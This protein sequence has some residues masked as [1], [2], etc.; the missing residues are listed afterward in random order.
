VKDQALVSVFLP[1]Y[2]QQ[3]FIADSICSV[4]SQ[5][6]ENI[7][8][9]I[10][11]DCSQDNTWQIVEEYKLKYPEKINAF[12]NK[13]NLGITGNCNEILRRCKGKYVVYTA[14]DDLFLPGKISAQVDLMS[15]NN[16][17]VLCYHDIE[18][19]KSKDNSTIRY[20]NRGIV[21][22]KPVVGLASKVAKMVI[23]DGTEFMAAL[24]VM[25]RRDSIPST[26]YD[27]RVPVASD[28]LMWIEILANSR[29]DA[30]VEFIPE[31]L[32]KYRM[33]DSNITATGHKHSADQYVTL[34]IVE[35]RYP[36][37]IK[38]I[39]K[40]LAKIRYRYGIRYINSGR[41][42]IGRKLLL[43]SFRSRWVSWKIFF[44]IAVTYFPFLLRLR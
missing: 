15:A 25:T 28:W 17:I 33:H 31:V 19:F 4:L 24:S 40:S 37:F 18:V 8:I 34:S 5:D 22:A 13:S 41:S 16:R 6:Y 39:N 29:D 23:E 21:S 11:D 1:T 3:Q 9:V 44:W 20:W 2:N 14:G 32:A 38:S 26:G 35:D 42:S 30:I 27:L 10:G 43:A 12:R 7:E 36:Q